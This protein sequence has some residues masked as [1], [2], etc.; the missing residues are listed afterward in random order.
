MNT[1]ETDILVKQARR[2][3]LRVRIVELKMV[4]ESSA[5]Y[6]SPVYDANGVVNMMRP[7]FRRNYREMAVVIGLNSA[8]M[9]CV[10]HTVGC[11]NPC[12]SPVY[13]GNVFKP[14]LLSNST[15]F[16]LMHN[17]PASSLHPSECDKQITTRL[18]EVGKLL[19]IEM[20]DHVIIDA[21]CEKCFS[22][23]DQGL[24]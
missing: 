5:E 9:P 21:D 23:K 3:K 12:S 18:K 14:L 11:G 2:G 7:F 24:L 16:I 1:P 10:I 8:N 17:H 4:R 19:E 22:F 13:V 6:G 20:T 15:R